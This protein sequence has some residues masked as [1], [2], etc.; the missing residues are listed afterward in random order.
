[1]RLCNRVVK[2]EFIPQAILKF[3]RP[4]NVEDVRT[5]YTGLL[6]DRTFFLGNLQRYFFKPPLAYSFYPTEGARTYRIRRSLLWGFFAVLFLL[7][8][9][10]VISKKRK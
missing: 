10:I 8:L 2:S 5:I 1:F 4:P 9:E 3:R 7:A 6:K